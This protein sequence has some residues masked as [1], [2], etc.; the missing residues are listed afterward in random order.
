ME[1]QTVAGQSLRCVGALFGTHALAKRPPPYSGV[2]MFSDTI[3][4]WC[5]V[6]LELD[7]V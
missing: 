3:P 2:T 7:N 5:E 1:A 4:E 6:T